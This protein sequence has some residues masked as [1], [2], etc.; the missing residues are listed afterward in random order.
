[1]K[2]IVKKGPGKQRISKT[3]PDPSAQ[4]LFGSAPRAPGKSDDNENAVVINIA[5]LQGMFR[6]LRQGTQPISE[7]D[8]WGKLMDTYY[9]AAKIK[10]GKRRADSIRKIA[11]EELRFIREGYL[12]E[13]HKKEALDYMREAYELASSEN[14]EDVKSHIMANLREHGLELDG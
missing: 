4:S 13:K 14:F 1:M 10:D 3:G 6:N 9:Y 11:S 5:V 7:E 12:A 8:I 2:V